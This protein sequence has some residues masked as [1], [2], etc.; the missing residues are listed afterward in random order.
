[1]HKSCTPEHK[2]VKNE[3]LNNAVEERQKI[4]RQWSTYKA[5]VHDQLAID[6]LSSG[7]SINSFCA[8]AK[9]SRRTYMAWLEVHPSFAEA[10]ELGEAQNAA[11]WEELGASRLVITPQSERIDEKMFKLNVLNRHNWRTTDANNLN[12]TVSADQQIDSARSIVAAARETQ[13]S[14]RK[15]LEQRVADELRAENPALPGVEYD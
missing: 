3:E 5:D 11:Y 4:Y 2:S 8:A 12:L 10:V 14:L 15:E 6:V 9:I 7:K 13:R 1:M